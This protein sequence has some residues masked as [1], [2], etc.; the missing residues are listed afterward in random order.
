MNQTIAKFARKQIL[1]KLETLPERSQEL[2]KLIYGRKNG[3]RS[4]EDTK[5]MSNKEV[6]A[7]MKDENLDWAL[8]QIEATQTK[9]KVQN[10][11][12]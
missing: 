2:F 11:I 3:K 6:L 4:V 8:T 5:K 1:E 9:F 7:E 12:L 10:G